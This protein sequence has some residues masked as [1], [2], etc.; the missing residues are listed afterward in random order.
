MKST[1]VGLAALAALSTAL[2]TTLA[3]PLNPRC[4]PFDVFYT[5]GDENPAISYSGNWTFI[6]DQN[7]NV[8]EAYSG[9][10]DA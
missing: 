3:V 9:D 8:T 4:S 6:N 10:L 5:Y 1:F 2:S 7:T